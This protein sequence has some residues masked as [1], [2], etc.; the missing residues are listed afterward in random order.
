MS[1]KNFRE[2]LRNKRTLTAYLTVGDPLTSDKTII[3]A[4]TISGVD[5]FELGIPTNMP[6]YDGPVIRAS[7]KRALE[8]GVTTDKAFKL[9]REFT[10][11]TG[12]NTVLL[13]YFSVALNYGLEDFIEKA[14]IAGVSCVLFPDLLIDYVDSLDVYIKLCENYGVEPAFF[15]TSCFPHRLIS[16]LAK[17]NPAFIYLGLMASTG[18]LLPI[19]ISKTIRIMKGLV[20]DIPLL[21]GFAISTP[22]QISNCIEAGADGIVIGSA[23][24]RLLETEQGENRAT[25]LRNFI[26]SLK[27]ALAG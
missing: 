1:N 19:T 5:I 10:T 17:L 7:H 21:A 11:I 13:T 15:I 26:L 8:K 12:A 3:E 6:K 4:L 22:Q 24:L 16:K 9:T 27:K 25:K 2:T 20:G 18:I 14:S 23:L